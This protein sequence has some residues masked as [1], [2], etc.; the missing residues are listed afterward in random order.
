MNSCKDT[1]E[2]IISEINKKIIDRNKVN[3][4]L[5]NTKNNCNNELNL[6]KINIDYLSND[7]IRETLNFTIIHHLYK[8][9]FQ[10]IY[11]FIN[12]NHYR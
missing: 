1:L 9:K 5:L 11:S 12:T 8:G 2:E 3:L 10:Y 7:Q 6:S 4:L